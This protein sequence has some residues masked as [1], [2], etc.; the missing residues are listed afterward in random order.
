MSEK[1][2]S[3]EHTYI[4]RCL[5]SEVNKVA[6]SIKTFIECFEALGHGVTLITHEYRERAVTTFDSI[7]IPSK[8]LPLDLKAIRLIRL[9]DRHG[10]TSSRLRDHESD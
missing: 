9:L 7:R 2:H 3:Y 4:F 8:V 1:R 5:L 6:T 10:G